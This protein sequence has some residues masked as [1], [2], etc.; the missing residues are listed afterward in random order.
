MPPGFGIWMILLLWVF[1]SVLTLDLTAPNTLPPGGGALPGTPCDDGDPNTSNDVWT[2]GCNCAGSV[3]IHDVSGSGELLTAVPNPTEGLVRITLEKANG[4]DIAYSV[5]NTL[6]EE[7]TREQLGRI[8][9]D[10]NGTIDLSEH[11]SGIYLVEFRIGNERR[12]IRLV[13]R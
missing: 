12:T 10:W 2:S 1:L 9:G 8:P 4:A 3:G 6:G 5:L 11:A 13:R 7:V